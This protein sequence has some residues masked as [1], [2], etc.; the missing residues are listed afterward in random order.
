V[1]SLC[2]CVR[3]SCAKVDG[4]QALKMPSISVIKRRLLEKSERIGE[5]AIW[6]TKTSFPKECDNFWSVLNANEGRRLLR[7]ERVTQ[8]T[9]DQEVLRDIG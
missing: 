1:P 7:K 8:S 3:N 9:D 4:Q 6:V 5:Q 2:L